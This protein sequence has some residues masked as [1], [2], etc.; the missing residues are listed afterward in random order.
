MFNRPYDVV[1]AGVGTEN[2]AVPA[3]LSSNFDAY[4]ENRQRYFMSL[5]EQM[6][7]M[8][9]GEESTDMTVPPPS[10]AD[11]P[12]HGAQ[13]DSYMDM[14]NVV[15]DSI[16]YPDEDPETLPVQHRSRAFA[17]PPTSSPLMI[18][19]AQQTE[20]TPS[21]SALPKKTRGSRGG[22]SRSA[23]SQRRSMIDDGVINGRQ[24]ATKNRREAYEQWIN[25]GR[26]AGSK[27]S[28]ANE[29]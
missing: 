1:D 10:A 3:G 24:K 19:P 16:E 5:Q 2:E 12:Q 27:P 20:S 13:E 22:R 23:S 15:P 25:T 17:L 18:E 9:Q 28:F 6:E 7:D 8:M 14:P 26:H 29:R 21:P 11:V 4:Q